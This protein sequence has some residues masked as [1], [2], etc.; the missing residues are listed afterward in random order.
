MSLRPMSH[1]E[2]KKC[3]VALSCFKGQGSS[4]RS[5]NTCSQLLD[6]CN[7]WH[8]SSHCPASVPANPQLPLSPGLSH[9]RTGHYL[10]GGGGGNKNGMG[11]GMLSFT[12]TKMGGGEKKVLAMLKRGWAQQVLW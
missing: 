1:V 8:L 5:V 11:G 6:L 2:F 7:I 10:R 4:S 12:P 3:T 9:L